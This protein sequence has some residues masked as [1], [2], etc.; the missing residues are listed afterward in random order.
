[1]SML[2][3][4]GRM[5]RRMIDFQCWA[6]RWKGLERLF[7]VN[8]DTHLLVKLDVILA[9]RREDGMLCVEKCIVLSYNAM[10]QVTVQL[11]IKYD[12]GPL[13]TRNIYCIIMSSPCS[14]P[15]FIIACCIID[16]RPL[17]RHSM[18]A[19]PL[20]HCLGSRSRLFCP[21]LLDLLQI[22]LS[23]QCRSGFDAR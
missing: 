20:R 12:G 16:P 8:N 21:R 10:L 2:V 13:C 5:G 3:G 4:M 11:G 7:Y 17:H 6:G 18:K 23:A 14:K 22:C 9:Y 15:E 19:P 1:V